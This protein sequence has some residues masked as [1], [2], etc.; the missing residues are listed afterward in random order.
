MADSPASDT[1]YGLLAEFD[2]PE[3]LVAAA[4]NA[5]R[6]G[7][8]RMDAFT[9]FPVDGLDTIL[10]IRDRR[11]LRLGLIGACLGASV[12]LAMQFF[13]NFDYPIN[14]GG[15]P[16]YPL[17]A[18]AV[19]TFE[20]TILFGALTPA[21]G[22]LFL[23]GLPRL[24]YPVFGASRFHLASRD[25]FFLCIKSN[26]RHFDPRKTAQFLKSLGAQSVEAVPS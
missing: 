23:N 9:P 18:F 11:V 3:A 1:L 2:S 20:L 14:V 15:R 19:V 7:F 26:D 25:R 5:R 16:L 17:T 10:R 4:K 6:E 12:A 22:M 13:T 24:N 8:R 21:F